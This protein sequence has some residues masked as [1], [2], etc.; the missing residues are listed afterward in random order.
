[1]KINR[2]KLVI[3]FLIVVIIQLTVPASM[4]I[5]RELILR[6]GESFKFK[7]APIDPY[8]PYRGRYVA[9]DIREDYAPLPESRLNI[10]RGDEIYA[11][12]KKNQE[13]FAY[14]NK[15]TLEVPTEASYIKAKVTYINR[16]E[17]KI[18]L[19]LPFER[20]YLDENIAPLVEKLYRKLN[21]EE[22]PNTYIKVRVKSGAA[23][24]EEL[25]LDNQAIIEFIKNNKEKYQED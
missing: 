16:K 24:I 4:I 12:L 6:Q 1:M 15:V 5:K 20:Y 14:F 19:D 10:S 7:T 9:L 8:D 13:G 17:N 25:Y 22:N 2:P 21:R 3:L 11:H 18:Y 23:V